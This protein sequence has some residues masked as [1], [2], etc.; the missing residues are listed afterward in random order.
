MTLKCIGALDKTTHYNM[1]KFDGLVVNRIIFVHCLDQFI[2]EKLSWQYHI[3]FVRDKIAKDFGKLK[4]CHNYMLYV[5][6]LNMYNSFLLPYLQYG[7]KVW[8]STFISYL[9]PLCV[10][11]KKF[12]RLMSNIIS[13]IVHSEPL[14][15][16][17]VLLLLGSVYSYSLA[18]FM[19]KIISCYYLTN[20]CDV[21]VKLHNIHCHEI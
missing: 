9:D 16:K 1:L 8:G 14:A 10:L 3:E 6:L 21:F 2:E 12:I 17:V 20:I 11:Q 13:N 7:I 5:C 19:F 15:Y 4:L 18:C